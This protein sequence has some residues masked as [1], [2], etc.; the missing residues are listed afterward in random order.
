MKAKV[1]HLQA[2]GITLLR[3]SLGAFYILHA[4]Y[5]AVVVGVE[6]IGALN[7]SLGVPLPL[8]AAW[9]VVLGHL[10]GGALLLLGLYPRLGAL[11]NVPIMAGAVLL[12]HGGQ[13]FFLHGVVTN[14]VTGT[15]SVGGYEY[16]L[17]LLLA[18]LAVCLTGGGPL[19]L[20]LGRRG[21]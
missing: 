1:K 19:S 9:G 3:A 4:Y 5:G 10:A 11:M 13:G 15:A 20:V 2:Y 14:P 18:T 17:F 16:A 12:V 21:G 6:R 7:A 8:I